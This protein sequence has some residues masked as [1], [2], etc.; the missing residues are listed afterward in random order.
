MSRNRRLA[1]RARPASTR[2][3]TGSPINGA[4]LATGRPRSVI[5]TTSPAAASVTTAEAF[6]FSA[7]MPTVFMSY[8]VAPCS[9]PEDHVG[10]ELV[11]LGHGD[12]G[13]RRRE[14]RDGVGSRRSLSLDVGDDVVGVAD[15]AEL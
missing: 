1:G 14:E 6:C 11:E 10:D 5:V 3:A 7:R 12:V 9:A 15:G 13:E 8:I 2:M 4:S